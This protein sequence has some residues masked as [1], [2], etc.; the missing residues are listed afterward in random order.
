MYVVCMYVLCMY[1]RMYVFMSVCVCT[2]VFMY[3]SV[4]FEV[5][6]YFSDMMIRY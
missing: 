2:C 1:V 3:E 6:E 5:S 4:Q